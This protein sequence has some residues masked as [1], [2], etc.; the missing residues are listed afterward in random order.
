[1]SSGKVHDYFTNQLKYPVS[2]FLGIILY[3]LVGLIGS[4]MAIIFCWLGCN[5]QRIAT[6]DLDINNGFYGFFLLRK[7]FPILA[8]IWE[9]YWKIYA[10]IIPHRSKLSHFPVISSLIRFIYILPL[11]FP[12]W[13]TFN[14]VWDWWLYFLIGI[15]LMDLGHIILDYVYWFRFWYEDIIKI[16]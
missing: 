13:W 16:E 2:L 12:L 6:P 4:I 9:Y 5:Y 8:L 1:M 11:L 3:P 15:I 10:L 14:I 7:K